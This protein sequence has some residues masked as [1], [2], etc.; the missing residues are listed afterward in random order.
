MLANPRA[1]GSIVPDDEKVTTRDIE[2]RAVSRLLVAN[3]DVH[4]GIAFNKA[5]DISAGLTY[6]LDP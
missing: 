1:S 4:L 5:R 2:P 3:D 6:H